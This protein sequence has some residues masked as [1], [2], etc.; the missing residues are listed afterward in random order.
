MREESCEH[1]HKES[2]GK[3][4]LAINFRTWAIEENQVSQE[5]SIKGARVDKMKR[6]I[7]KTSR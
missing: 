2:E 6:I 7:N 3:D 4:D 1:E 5:M